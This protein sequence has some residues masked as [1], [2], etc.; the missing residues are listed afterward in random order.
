[1]HSLTEHDNSES[2]SD[3]IWSCRLSLVA[4][5]LQPSLEISTAAHCQVATKPDGSVISAAQAHRQQYLPAENHARVANPATHDV[6]HTV[7]KFLSL[8]AC[9]PIRCCHGQSSWAGIQHV[10]KRL[11]YTN[12]WQTPHRSFYFLHAWQQLNVSHRVAWRTF[13]SWATGIT[14]VH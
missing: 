12:S 10:N 5:V 14:E 7:L 4:V 6:Q 9:Q 2:N 3:Y 13:T 1:M 8:L 11:L